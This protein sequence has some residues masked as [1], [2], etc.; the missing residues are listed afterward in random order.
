MGFEDFP[1]R[2]VDMD[3]FSAGDEPDD[4][5]EGM[6]DALRDDPASGED[7]RDAQ[8]ARIVERFPADR[9]REAVRGR[10]RMLS[11][12]DGEA[13]LRLVEAYATPGLLEELAEALEDQPDLPPERAWGALSLLEGAGMLEDFPNLAERWDE[14]GETLESADD[15]LETLVSQLE[16]EPEGSWVALQGLGAVEPEVR[17]EI[18]EGLARFPTSPGLVNFLRL[19]AFAHDPTTRLAALD[20]LAGRAELDD[21]H[22]LAWAEIAHDHPDAE[23]R[24][25]AIHLLGP[26]SDQSLAEALRRPER[27]RPRVIGQLVTALDGAG[28]GL[29]LIASMD[30]GRLVVA[31][32][33]CD[34]WRGIL[35]VSGQDDDADDNPSLHET[36][37]EEFEAQTERDF[38]LDA[39]GLAEGLL[40]GAL[41][42]CEP[43][44]NPVLRYWLER[45]VGPA[46]RPRPFGGLVR[47]EELA[48]H[49]LEAMNESV[50]LILGACPD[51]IDASDLT[52]E[53]AEEIALRSG[54]RPPDP[55]LDAGAYRYLFEHRLLGRLE[56][57]RRM[58]LWMASFWQGSGD[59]SLARSSLALAWQLSDPQHAVPGHPFTV[60]LT[61]RSLI[62]AQEDIRAS[63]DRRGR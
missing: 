57:Y 3:A 49:A 30:R 36:I 18:I 2:G 38:V 53:I 9:L 33:L 58:L 43:E 1:K 55:R 13:I 62:A 34:V 23:V 41:L 54:D 5:P 20:A 63:Q 16:E 4:S 22:R 37:F 27:A 17:A 7:A 14:L 56:H 50:A 52:Y 44:T 31:S 46:F 35:E 21:E 28:Q 15:A 25:R 39:P 6:L 61:T 11:G 8:L 47:D 19:L 26:D 42:V 48:S 10:L 29:I 51:W 59:P 32:F 45:T 40:A 24:T 60:A 12:D